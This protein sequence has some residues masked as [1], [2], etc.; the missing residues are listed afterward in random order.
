VTPYLNVLYGVIRIFPFPLPRKIKLLSLWNPSSHIYSRQATMS[1]AIRTSDSD[2][3]A[4]ARAKYK[5]VESE[6]QPQSASSVFKEMMSMI[7]SECIACYTTPS[8]FKKRI[9]CA[10][11]RSYQ[12]DKTMR[13]VF[14]NCSE[15][16]VDAY[17]K[18]LKLDTHT[19]MV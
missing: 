12:T 2:S 19:R 1:L 17:M 16:V 7:P 4:L 11:E 14:E 5:H 15:K 18:N 3:K 13:L 9:R 6:S 10:A 8:E